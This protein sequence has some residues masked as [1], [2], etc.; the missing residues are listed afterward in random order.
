MGTFVFRTDLLHSNPIVD[1]GIQH[2]AAEPPL[3]AYFEAWQGPPKGEP[4]NRCGVHPETARHLFD[5]QIGFILHEEKFTGERCLF[6]VKAGEIS[7]VIV[8]LHKR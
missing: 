3:I 8:Q 4:I 1:P 2:L 5:I 7:G 6:L